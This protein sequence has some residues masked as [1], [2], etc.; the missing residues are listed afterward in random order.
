MAVAQRT[1]VIYIWQ[2]ITLTVCSLASMADVSDST[3][4]YSTNAKP[5]DLPLFGSVCSH[6]YQQCKVNIKF[7]FFYHI[8]NQIVKKYS[9]I[10]KCK[11]GVINIL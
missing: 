6:K 10:E 3:D 4:L 2:N 9:Q 11:G 8:H 5:R 1:L 7:R